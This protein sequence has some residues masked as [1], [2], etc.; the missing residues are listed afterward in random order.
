MRFLLLFVALDMKK[1]HQRLEN[2]ARMHTS[3]MQSNNIANNNTNI[4][5][6]SH[7]KSESKSTLISDIK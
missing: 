2:I 5:N 7:Y 1:M 3:L 6:T 4:I